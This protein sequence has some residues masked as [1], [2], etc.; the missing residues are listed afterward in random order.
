MPETGRFLNADGIV[1]TGQGMLDK[2]MF[3]Y[4]L[5]NPVNMIDSSG[6]FGKKIKE[7]WNSFTNWLFGGFDSKKSNDR[8]GKLLDGYENTNNFRNV[9]KNVASEITTAAENLVNKNSGKSS[10]P[11]KSFKN[12]KLNKMINP[13]LTAS[14]HAYNKMIQ[15][16]TLLEKMKIVP[17]GI[18]GKMWSELQDETKKC[19]VENYLA[20]DPVAVRK[21][22]YVYG[23]DI[24]TD[25]I[26]DVF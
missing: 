23:V 13:N 7:L 18:E 8:N 21:I 3:A 14:K 25:L 17:E 12:N 16:F 1:Q 6:M 2:N 4:C 22:G 15:E 26:N 5:N 11:N 10:L 24:T 9:N 20:W 19:I